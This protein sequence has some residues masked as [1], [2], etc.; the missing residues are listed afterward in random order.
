MLVSVTS[1]KGCLETLAK[2][3]IHIHNRYIVGHTS[4]LLNKY[5]SGERQYTFQV[6]KEQNASDQCLWISCSPV[7]SPGMSILCA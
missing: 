2:R 5:S 3:N 4:W 7:K 1:L 6:C